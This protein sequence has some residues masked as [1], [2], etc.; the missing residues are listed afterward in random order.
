MSETVLDLLE[1]AKHRCLLATPGYSPTEAAKAVRDIERG[2]LRTA[3]T[4]RVEPRWAPRV[5]AVMGNIVHACSCGRVYTEGDLAR[6]ELLGR[7]PGFE[8][9]RC[10]CGRTRM[11]RR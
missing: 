2:N 11:I 1:A 8:W 4:R 10:T 9:R 7:H 5:A 3:S 6:L